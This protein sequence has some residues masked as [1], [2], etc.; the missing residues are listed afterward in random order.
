MCGYWLRSAVLPRRVGIVHEL[1]RLR[2]PARRNLSR[3]RSLPRARR[4][5][6]AAR[7]T[8]AASADSGCKF[9]RRSRNAPTSSDNRKI[10]SANGKSRHR[11]RSAWFRGRSAGGGQRYAGAEPPK[12]PIARPP[13]QEHA[14]NH[15]KSVGHPT[16]IRPMASA[17]NSEGLHPVSLGGLC[18]KGMGV[19]GRSGIR[20]QTEQ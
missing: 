9:P 17:S 16:R 11:A 14:G 18:A 4:A 1:A 7:L 8:P 2:G 10:D 5:R 12:G 6:Q 19:P 13:T 15:H 20:R 3:E